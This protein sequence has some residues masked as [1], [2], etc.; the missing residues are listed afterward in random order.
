MQQL[1]V[2]WEA[3]RAGVALCVNFFFFI[4]PSCP[5]SYLSEFAHARESPQLSEGAFTSDDRLTQG[6][7]QNF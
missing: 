1:R 5:M 3:Q 6:R 2:Y 7:I 4:T